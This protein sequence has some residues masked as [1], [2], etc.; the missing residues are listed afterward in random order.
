MHRR[1]SSGSTVN[2]VEVC[3]S[4][5]SHSAAGSWRGLAISVSSG[6]AKGIGAGG[7]GVRGRWGGYCGAL[8]T[9]RNACRVLLRW[10]LGAHGRLL[11]QVMMD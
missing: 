2:N 1:A 5:P 7:D 3:D 6:A 9:G 11:A 10:P 4:D 8:G